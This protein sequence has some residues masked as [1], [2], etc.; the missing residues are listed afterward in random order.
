MGVRVLSSRNLKRF[1]R[2]DES[3][4]EDLDLGLD[5]PLSRE[6]E[7]TLRQASQIGHLSQSYA[8]CTAAPLRRPTHTGSISIESL[9]NE[10]H[11]SPESQPSM[12]LTHSSSSGD[13]PVVS[14][15][16]TNT[17]FLRRLSRLSFRAPRRSS[18]IMDQTKQAGKQRQTEAESPD[19]SVSKSGATTTAAT[20]IAT[21]TTATYTDASAGTANTGSVGNA[22]NSGGATSRNGSAGDSNTGNRNGSASS[23]SNPGNESNEV[24]SPQSFREYSL[25]PMHQSSVTS[26]SGG[27]S[28]PA[29]SLIFERSVQGDLDEKTSAL[30]LHY[31]EDY[32]PPVLEASANAITDANFDPDQIE[33]VSLRHRSSSIMRSPPPT[34]ES[35]GASSPVDS[36]N[37]ASAFP[38]N[39][40]QIASP[41]LP[42][43][44][45]SKH[46]P[47]AINTS[48]GLGVDDANVPSPTG[49]ESSRHVLSFYSFADILSAEHQPCQQQQQPNQ[50]HQLPHG[51]SS[52]KSHRSLS[53]VQSGGGPTSPLV[54]PISSADDD[55]MTVTSMRETLRRN[56]GEIAGHG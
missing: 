48:V 6:E 30:G 56:T 46:A 41:S 9:L 42:P 8:S 45:L 14:S 19:Q 34:G 50:Q 38:G 27:F 51:A 20:S 10:R 53:P 39:L 23:A 29:S 44:Q 54:S 7:L 21:A 28:S 47:P 49:S 12:S 17:R 16:P 52:I 32:I 33:V 25:S 24:G 43:P 13:T 37:A 26:G 5:E 18:V 55:E 4:D 40:S 35:T 3:D 15:S 22:S 31:Q 11:L 36:Q 2:R 1:L